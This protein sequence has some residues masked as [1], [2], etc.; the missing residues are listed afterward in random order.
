[1]QEGLLETKKKEAQAINAKYDD[2]RKR[3]RELTEVRKK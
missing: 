3:Y 1:M 2:D